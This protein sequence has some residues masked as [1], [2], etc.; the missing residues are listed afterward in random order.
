[1]NLLEAARYSF[2]AGKFDAALALLDQLD[3]GGKQ[4]GESL[5]LRG[6]I[7]MEQGKLRDAEKLFRA[8]HAAS[9]DLF[10]PRL[11]L[12]DLFFREKKYD[13]ARAAYL[14]I[15][16]ETTILTSNERLRYGILLTFLAQHDEKQARQVFDQIVFP[17]E[18]PAYYYAQSAW[19]FFHHQEGDARKWLNTG[20]RI[21]DPA[22][23]AWFA[24]PLYE[25]G[26]IK[27]KPQLVAP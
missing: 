19:G 12:G 4:S 7:R 21:F 17:T 18:T 24:E 23:V 1:V 22:S 13:E 9:A 26:W 3:K 20:N 16:K 14:E 10:T 6:T 15:L 5:D 2:E 11:H 8:A 25:F 27:K